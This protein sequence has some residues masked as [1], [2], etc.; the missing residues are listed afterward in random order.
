MICAEPV[1][2]FAML[3]E[4]SW[5][6]SSSFWDTCRCKRPSV[7][8]AAS[9]EFDRQSTIASDRTQPL[10][11]PLGGSGRVA[12]NSPRGRFQFVLSK[13]F[14]RINWSSDTGGRVIDGQQKMLTG[15][16]ELCSLHE[17]RWEN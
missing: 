17:A 6:R 16:W 2:G 14:I 11:K 3:R 13:P 8:S 12:D 10:T 1:L 7:T 4:A 9:N 15:P 5:S